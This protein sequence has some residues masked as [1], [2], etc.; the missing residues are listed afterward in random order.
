MPR[1]KPA[2][3]RTL[4]H[5]YSFRE[6]D[7]VGTRGAGCC[8]APPVV[9]APEVDREETRVPEQRADLGLRVDIVA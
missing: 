1:P 5:S 6:P 3:S 9:T 2:V 8:I 7:Q 4:S